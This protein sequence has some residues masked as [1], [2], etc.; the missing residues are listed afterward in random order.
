MIDIHSH[1]LYGLDDGARDQQES[2]AMLKVAGETGTTDIVATPH[3]NSQFEYNPGRV[4]E[5]IRELNEIS[6]NTPRIHRGCDFHMS[7]DNV[8]A[9]LLDHT[10][11]TIN[12]LC[13]LMVEF[14]DFFV[15]P[16]TDD[17]L[18]ELTDRGIRPVITH[19]ER[20]PILRD[21]TARLEA[22]IGTGCLIQVTAQSLTDRFGRESRDAAWNWLRKGMVHVLA[23]DAHDPVH[24]P[25]RLDLAHALV[26]DKLGS[27]AADLLL[28][29]N[30]G[31]IIQ[32]GAVTSM[33]SSEST[34]GKKWFQ[35]WR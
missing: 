20:N 28:T 33:S 24:R 30:P 26:T 5:Q 17:V 29:A 7:V 11:F 22:W 13:Y 19:P 18:R 16:S 23:S 35:F 9:C 27:E 14:A 8:Q 31:A 34:G 32:G 10:P 2:L 21:S 4:D 15:P 1:I 6:N 12:G 25:P 3:S